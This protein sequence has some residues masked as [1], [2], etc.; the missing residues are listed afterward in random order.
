MMKTATKKMHDLPARQ[1]AGFVGHHRHHS[2][3]CFPAGQT[4]AR[5]Q[6]GH[7]TSAFQPA[8]Q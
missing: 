1:P 5:S 6:A 8:R 4:V 7:H 3:K 2:F